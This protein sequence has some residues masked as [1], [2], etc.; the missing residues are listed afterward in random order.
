MLMTILYRKMFVADDKGNVVPRPQKEL[1]SADTGLRRLRGLVN[2]VPLYSF[3]AQHSQLLQFVRSVGSQ[4]IG[5]M[6]ASAFQNRVSKQVSAD[7][8]KESFISTGIPMLI[9][10]I[11]WLNGQVRESGSRLVVTFLPPQRWVV[12]APAEWQ[13]DL[14]VRALADLSASDGIPFIDVT[15]SVRA[16]Q[17]SLGK[18]LFY[19]G[20]DEHPNPAGYQVFAETI[21]EYLLSQRLVTSGEDVVLER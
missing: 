7:S 2:A 15:P 19:Q 18:S 10:E 9:G 17:A 8:V 1:V 4:G 3:L 6:R 14:I 5:R 13:S 12:K 11:R 21:S 16:R 20:R